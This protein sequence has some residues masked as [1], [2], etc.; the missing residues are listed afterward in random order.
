MRFLLTLMLFLASFSIYADTAI[1]VEGL[2]LYYWQSKH[3]TNFGDHLSLKLVERIVGGKVKTA[4]GS[5]HHKLLA[6]GS[7]LL[8]AKTDDVVWGTGMNAKRL[9]LKL[10]NFKR[11]DIRAVRG[12]LTRDFI[13]KNFDIYCPEVY[14]D[15]ALLLPYFF[16]EFKKKQN[17]EF[18]YVIVPHYSEEDLF[19]KSLYPN[20]IYPT[21]PWNDVVRKIIN[22]K[23][24]IAGSLHGVIVAEAYNI[25]ARYLRL[26]DHEPL[27]KYQDY[28]L[29][30]NRP[31]F[32]YATTVEEALLMGGEPPFDCDLK[33]LY[34][35]F[36][37]EYWPNA[38]FKHPT[39]NLI[40]TL[41]GF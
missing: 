10:Y 31:N 13:M 32:R 26:S 8:F 3:F 20:V 1:E 17:P 22:S 37:F 33:K 14:G 36:P 7:V 27:F 29:G 40:Q 25:P 35:S 12:P 39:I 23:F 6:I 19:P 4:Y 30:T 34:E 24:V 18:D 38:N 16:P 28:Y 21:E 2:P 5:D 15:P 9:D 11:L 41:D